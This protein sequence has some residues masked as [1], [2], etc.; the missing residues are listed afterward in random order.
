MDAD[1]SSLRHH[2]CGIMTHLSKCALANVHKEARR[3]QANESN[4]YPWPWRS[5]SPGL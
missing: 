2:A 3:E 1:A 5:R 4:S